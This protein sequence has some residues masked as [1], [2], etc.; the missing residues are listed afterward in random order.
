MSSVASTTA[1]VVLVLAGS[2][3]AMY[4]TVGGAMWAFVSSNTV[5]RSATNTAV[6]PGVSS[7]TPVPIKTSPVAPE[8]MIQNTAVSSITV[9]PTIGSVPAASPLIQA[10][11]PTKSAHQ[12]PNVGAGPALVIT[13]PPPV[14]S[15][16]P[17]TIPV[18]ASAT[19]APAKKNKA[20][21]LSYVSSI[22]FAGF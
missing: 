13:S 19:P 6:V 18:I 16:P 8:T 12:S 11:A 15:L 10:V 14:A 7:K 3:V 21:A 5:D 1:T 22:G 2:V 4:V 17:T 9:A 20:P